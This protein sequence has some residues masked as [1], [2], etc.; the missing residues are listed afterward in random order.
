MAA[1]PVAPFPRAL[2]RSLH[3]GNLFDR[4]LGDLSDR[5]PISRLPDRPV[6]AEFSLVTGLVTGFPPPGR[7]VWREPS[8]PYEREPGLLSEAI[9][10]TYEK[11]TWMPVPAPTEIWSL[12]SGVRRRMLTEVADGAPVTT[13]VFTTPEEALVSL[14][15][16]EGGVTPEMEKSNCVEEA[17]C[18]SE[19]RLAKSEK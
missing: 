15:S 16:P 17:K 8:C 11:V 4:S 1:I 6:P 14:P 3:A 18:G 10:Q 5:D 9:N 12:L 7:P 2:R 13:T 19:I